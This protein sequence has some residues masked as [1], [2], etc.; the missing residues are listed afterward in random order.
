[1]EEPNNLPGTMTVEEC[2]AKLRISRGAAYSEIANTDQL[3]GVKAIRVGKRIIFSR[4][5]FLRA[6]DG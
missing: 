5:Q 3:I 2:A 1:M 6:L 4:K